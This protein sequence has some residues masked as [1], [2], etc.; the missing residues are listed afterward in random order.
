MAF[1]TPLAPSPQE[2]ATP[3]Q[4]P[5]PGDS[6]APAAPDGTSANPISTN[7]MPT[8]SYDTYPRGDHASGRPRRG[9]PACHV[10]VCRFS[11]WPRGLAMILPLVAS[12]WV[13]IRYFHFW[14]R[15][16]R[17]MHDDMYPDHEPTVPY[18]I[19]TIGM[20]AALVRY[21]WSPSIGDTCS[22]CSQMSIFERIRDVCTHKS[23][24]G[25]ED[26][27]HIIV[28]DGGVFLLTFGR[29]WQFIL[30]SIYLTVVA[31]TISKQLRD[32]EGGMAFFVHL[33][34][35][36]VLAALA[37]SAVALAPHKPS[38]V[39]V[40][41]SATGSILLQEAFWVTWVYCWASRYGIPARG[42]YRKK[43]ED[44]Q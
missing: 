43:H 19:F 7:P 8:Y 14:M 32:K 33:S 29:L 38:T 1:L 27:S 16:S 20:I 25:R 4:Q 28:V 23:H 35:A 9:P 40:L 41:A 17:R 12:F 37:Y 6:A 22:K 26:T 5:A 13:P 15:D 44:Q 36:L 11:V 24:G 2:K 39:W 10:T 30:S 18:M 34:L 31:W 42:M 21:P 3:T